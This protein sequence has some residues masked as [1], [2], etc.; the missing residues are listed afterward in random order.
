MCLPQKRLRAP[1]FLHALPQNLA[2]HAVEKTSRSGFWTRLDFQSGRL[3]REACE[4]M[5]SRLDSR[6]L[7]SPS[8]AF[9]DVQAK[10][11]AK[12]ATREVSYACLSLGPGRVEE[13]FASP[14]L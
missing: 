5:S 3:A 11:T 4:R 12:V 7:G 1:A 2:C 9:L 14:I 13:D 8:A 10:T 6:R